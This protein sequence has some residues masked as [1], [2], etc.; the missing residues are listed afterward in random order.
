ML[1]DETRNQ[2]AVRDVMRSQLAM[3]GYE[4]T[5]IEALKLMVQNKT[6]YLLVRLLNQI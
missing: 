5:A 4:K 1:S 3:V 6:K 2:T